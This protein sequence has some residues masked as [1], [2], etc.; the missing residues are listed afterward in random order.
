MSA[1]NQMVVVE[2]DGEWEVW[3]DAC[4]DNP[5]PL[6]ASKLGTYASLE[7]AMSVA[8]AEYTEYG[9]HCIQGP[10][11]SQEEA[12]EAWHQEVLQMEQNLQSWG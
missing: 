6:S 11:P 1:N 10:V 7:D 9:V 3:H 8:N 2:L 5:F 12:E 4:V